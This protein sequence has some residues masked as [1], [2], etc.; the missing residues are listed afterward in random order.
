MPAKRT[1][2]TDES[3][4]TV[5]LLEQIKKLIVLQLLADGV[6]SGAIADTLNVNK[7]VVSRLVPARK[8]MRQLRKK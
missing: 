7:S 3:A 6:P 8:L 2:R 5:A 4:A 1:P